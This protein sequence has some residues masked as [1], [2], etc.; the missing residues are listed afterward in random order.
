VEWSLVTKD[1]CFTLYDHP[2]GARSFL[3]DQFLALS[4]PHQGSRWKQL[5]SFA[6]VT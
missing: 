5:T 3:P 6:Q 1:D 4:N 2:F